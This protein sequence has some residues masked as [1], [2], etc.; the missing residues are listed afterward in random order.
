MM[1]VVRLPTT[2]EYVRPLLKQFCEMPQVIEV[3]RLT[4]ED[5]FNLSPWDLETIVDSIAR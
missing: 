4:G 1:A 2:H 3:L 5:C